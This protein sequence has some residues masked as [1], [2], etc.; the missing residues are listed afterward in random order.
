MFVTLHFNSIIKVNWFN[1]R[2]SF[3]IILKVVFVI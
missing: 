2:T 1:I 3:E